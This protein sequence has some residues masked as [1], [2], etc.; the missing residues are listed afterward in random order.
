MCLIRRRWHIWISLCLAWM[1]K[2]RESAER[3]IC[4]LINKSLENEIFLYSHEI[5][6]NQKELSFDLLS[7]SNLFSLKPSLA[8]Y[9]LPSTLKYSLNYFQL[10]DKPPS[11]CSTTQNVNESRV[12]PRNVRSV[13]ALTVANVC[14]RYQLLEPTKKRFLYLFSLTMGIIK[15]KRAGEQKIKVQLRAEEI[16]N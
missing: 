12:L 6:V 14:R 11:Y 4:G 8:V 1:I 9:F 3:T 5:T 10:P 15:S 16:E 7:S 2:T 13:F